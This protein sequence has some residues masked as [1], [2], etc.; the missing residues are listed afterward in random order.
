MKTL[1]TGANGYIGLRLIPALLE[2]GHHVTALV[3]DKARFPCAQFA[4]FTAEGRFT[5]IEGDML[6]PESLPELPAK[7]CAAYY[8]LHSM[9]AGGDF[10]QRE[11]A[12]AT[13]FTTWINRSRCQRILYLGGLV[14]DAPLSHHLESRENV[15]RILRSGTIPVTTLRAS[16]IVGSGSASFEII[17][18]LAERLPFMITPKWANTR[19]QPIAIRNVITYLTGC[20]DTQITTGRELDIGGPEVL[21]YRTLLEQYAEVRNLRRIIIS[22]PFLTPRL[23]AHWLHLVTA[24]TIPLAKSLIS[25]LTN[26]TICRENTITTLIP[27]NL[28][29]YRQ[30]IEKAFAR[31]AQNRIP[32]SWIDAL[33]TGRI[34]PAFLNSVRVPEHGVLRDHQT[35]PLETQPENAIDAVWSLGGTN[36]WPAMN[37]AWRIRGWID[38]FT[39]GI[40][41]RRGRRHPTELNPGDA[42]DFWR[43]LLADQSPDKTSARL[44][45][46]A[47][48]KL[49]GEAWL[50]FEITPTELRQTATFRPRGL[51]GRIYWYSVLPFHLALFPR[52]AHRLAHGA[53]HA[54][55]PP[56]RP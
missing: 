23:S 22:V 25:S 4:P 16:I 56:A 19:C 13:N 5:L 40:G 1:V 42:L 32:S 28:L 8:L 49:P 6:R 2:A 14:P 9:A 10:E 27:Q 18:D 43:V 46:F 11:A 36:G 34:N 35:V 12:C 29:T 51:L 30:A 31:I 15:N 38:R 17:R 21:T 52:M 54:T 26:E 44:I 48:M 39:G 3:R 33:S 53:H 41:I 37:W 55:T 47:E 7:L 50:D 20:L 45:L 24:T